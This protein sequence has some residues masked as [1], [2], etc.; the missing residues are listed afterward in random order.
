MRRGPLDSFEGSGIPRTLFAILGVKFDR[1]AERISQCGSVF[2]NA[3]DWEN[4]FASAPVHIQWDPERTIRGAAQNHFSIQVGISRQLIRE[5]VDQWIVSI[6]DLTPTVTK[7]R[8][9]M[10][11]GNEKNARRLLPSER[12]YPIA[13]EIG[14]RILID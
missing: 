4:L 5:Y 3:S 8:E 1:E 7:I 6:E 12:V 11:S 14:R 10:R 9:S 13:A 2:R